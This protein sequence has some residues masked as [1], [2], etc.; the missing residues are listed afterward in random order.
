MDT[1]IRETPVFAPVRPQPEP[2][3]DK[4]QD[5]RTGQD[6][7]TGQFG[8]DAS[9]RSIDGSDFLIEPGAGAPLRA[10][11]KDAIASGGSPK[12]AVN[13]HI[14]AARRAAQAALAETA[15]NVARDRVRPMPAP[16]SAAA[17]GSGIEQAKAFFVARRRPILLGVALVALLAIAAVELG[18]MRQP[19]TQKSEVERIVEP[20]LAELAPAKEE[21]K[22]PAPA[23]SDIR[24]LDTTPV[25]SI[26]PAPASAPAPKLLTPAPAELVASIPSGTP[27]GLRDAAAAGDAAAQYELASR[28]ADGRN[29]TRDPHAAAQ[30]CER[31]AAQGLA[32]AQY[33]IGSFY[34]KGIGVTRDAPLAR[35]WYKKAAEAGNVRAMHN[36]AV[37]IAQGAGIKPD[38][39]EAADWFQKAAQLGVKDSQY[40]LAILYARGMG[41]A[42]DLGQSWFWFSLA[43]QQGD[44]DAAKKRDEVAAKMDA[45]ALAAD[46]AALA[47]FRAATPNPAANEVAAPPGG[48]DF[49]KTTAA[50]P[51]PSSPPPQA[52][53]PAPAASRSLSTPM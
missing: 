18:V 53:A 46:K 19:N 12:N 36:L 15:S 2:R 35:A 20:K 16:A 7:R 39:S 1:T 4:A 6:P 37:L 52:A 31:A 30:W 21:S 33:R 44:A 29:M 41:L 45:G 27:P 8:A 40:N 23:K 24:A 43:A 13:A 5:S 50:P 11:E 38:Y 3:A 22:P 47:N 34:E 28:L 25:G 42:Q 26:N 10:L 48:W 9:M 17:G 51:A 32:P 14:A 49:A